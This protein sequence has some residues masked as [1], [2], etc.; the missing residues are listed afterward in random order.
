MKANTSSRRTLEVINDRNNGTR[1]DLMRALMDGM[2]IVKHIGERE[3]LFLFRQISPNLDSSEIDEDIK[4]K[5]RR[6]SK[7]S[8]VNLF[9]L[10]EER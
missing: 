10:L 6:R 9:C 8:V 3:A 5:V 7:L 1:G 4:Q 2:Y